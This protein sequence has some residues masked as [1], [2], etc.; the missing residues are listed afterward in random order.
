MRRFLSRLGAVAVAAVPRTALRTALPVASSQLRAF[1][2]TTTAWQSAAAPHQHTTQAHLRLAN[3]ESKELRAVAQYT[4]DF[5]EVEGRRPRIL[6]CTFED[7]TQGR[8]DDKFAIV[9]ADL[10]F[11][12]DIGP[13]KQSPE[14][15]AR[16]AVEADVHGIHVSVLTEAGAVPLQRLVDCLK[17]EDAEDIFVTVAAAEPPAVVPP[18]VVCVTRG[19]FVGAAETIKSLLQASDPAKTPS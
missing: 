2:S 4:H 17:Q 5:A 14:Q 9:M 16:Q 10:G 19:D 11:D 12:V 1:A 13:A 7:C 3:R 18:R 15:I 8:P 6:L